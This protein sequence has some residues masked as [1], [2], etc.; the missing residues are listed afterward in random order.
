MLHEGDLKK[1]CEVLGIVYDG[2]ASEMITAEVMFISGE[3]IAV[4]RHPGEVHFNRQRVYTNS[5][6]CKRF[7]GLQIDK[8]CPLH[9]EA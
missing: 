8:R 1:A 7:I 4:T 9:E 6:T 5:C 2:N 3:V